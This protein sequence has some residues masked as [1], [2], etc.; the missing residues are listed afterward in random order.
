MSMDLSDKPTFELD[1]G[2]LSI[3]IGEQVEE[4]D[5]IGKELA[6]AI[7]AEARSKLR[8]E[9]ERLK[10]IVDLRREYRARDEKM[11]RA[12][13]TDALVR[14]RLDSEMWDNYEETKAA[15][16]ALRTYVGIARATLNARQSL[17]AAARDEGKAQYHG[18]LPTRRTHG[19]SAYD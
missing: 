10:I 19:A 8:I 15:V 5:K 6:G 13:V 12:D 9:K 4:L 11:P 2:K 18:D 17:L 14:K 1:Y 3:K 7:R 16:D